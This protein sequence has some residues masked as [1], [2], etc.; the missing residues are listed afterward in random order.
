MVG[1][2]YNRLCKGIGDR[3]GGHPVTL[4]QDKKNEKERLQSIQPPGLPLADLVRLHH[5]KVSKEHQDDDSWEPRV[6]GYVGAMPHS[7]HKSG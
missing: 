5:L 7:N 1:K 2:A 3:I 6:K 4:H